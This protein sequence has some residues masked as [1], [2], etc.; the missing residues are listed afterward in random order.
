LLIQRSDN[1]EFIYAIPFYAVAKEAWVCIIMCWQRFTKSVNSHRDNYI[2][3]YIVPIVR[4]SR[5]FTFKVTR[6]IY[7]G[8]CTN[9]SIKWI[10]C[11]VFMTHTCRFSGS[12]KIVLHGWAYI[13]T[14]RLL[15]D[16]TIVYNMYKALMV[17]VTL[18]ARS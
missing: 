5:N 14:W 13:L 16:T 10:H 11:A 18:Q 9:F 6:T 3:T 8:W 12:V 15:H 7:Y 2:N 1:Q 17:N 4:G